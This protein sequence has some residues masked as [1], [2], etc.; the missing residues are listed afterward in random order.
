MN[1]KAK[2][3]QTEKTQANQNSSDWHK[4]GVVCLTIVTSVGGSLVFI[5]KQWERQFDFLNANQTAAESRTEKRF[6]KIDVRFDKID[7]RFDKQDQKIDSNQKEL[8]SLLK[9]KK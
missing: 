7:A 8:I 9:S 6:D 4:V 2:T 5:S 1:T 3:Q